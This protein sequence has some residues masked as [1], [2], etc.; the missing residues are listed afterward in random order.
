[1]PIQ[2]MQETWV[3]FL[4]QEDP[5][6]EGLATHSKNVPAWKIPWTEELGRATV[7]GVAESGM[8][9]QS[10]TDGLEQGFILKNN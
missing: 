7:P 1:M 5:L 3:R 6:E 4:D 8:T 2:E 9:E 10:G